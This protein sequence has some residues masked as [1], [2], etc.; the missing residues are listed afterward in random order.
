MVLEVTAKTPDGKVVYHDSKVYMPVPQQLGRGD[1]MGRGP[2]D[3]SGILVDWAFHPLEEKKEEY[4]IFLPAKDGK[5]ENYEYIVEV[6]LWYVPF[7]SKDEYSQLWRK[8][9]QKITFSKKEPY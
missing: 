1:R 5:L 4:R 9:T 3:K 2:Y 8:T 6:E 7:G